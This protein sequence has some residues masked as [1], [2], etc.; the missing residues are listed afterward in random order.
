MRFVVACTVFEEKLVCAGRR[1]FWWCL[2]RNAAQKEKDRQTNIVSLQVPRDF[3][4]NQCD[5]TCKY[6]ERGHLGLEPFSELLFDRKTEHWYQN[7]HTMA[8][9]SG[10]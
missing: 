10:K 9:I 2:G 5:S 3:A 1:A 8:G 7:M 4:A 6:I